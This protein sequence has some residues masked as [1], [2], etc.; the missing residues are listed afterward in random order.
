MEKDDFFIELSTIDNLVEKNKFI[1]LKFQSFI[2]DSKINLLNDIMMDEKLLHFHPSCLWA[3]TL[4]TKNVKDVN[5][6]LTRVHEI[7]N[8]VKKNYK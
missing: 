5:D 7:Y 4:M 1:L 6:A 8:K 3:I 2:Y